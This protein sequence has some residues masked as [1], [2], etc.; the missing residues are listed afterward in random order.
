MMTDEILYAL[1]GLLENY[2]N[3]EI[4]KDELVKELKFLKEN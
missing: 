4:T 1:L 2:F 3:N